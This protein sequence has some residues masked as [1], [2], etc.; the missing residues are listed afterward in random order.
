[1]R[2]VIAA[3]I[4][5]IGIVMAL[6]AAVPATAASAQQ[7]RPTFTIT[8]VASG[9]AIPWDVAETPDGTLIFDQR[10]GGLSVRRPNGTVSSLSADFSDLYTNGETGLMGLVLDPG[11]ATNRRFYTCQGHQAG[12]AREIQVI[13]WTVDPGYT[14]A[15]RVNDPLLGG[16]PANTASGRHGGCRLRFDN[17]GALMVST[18]DA[19]TGSVPQDLTSLGGKILRINPENGDPAAGNPGIN[20][21]NRSTRL[22]WNYGHRNPQ[23]LALRPNGQMFNVEHGPGRDDEVNLVLSDRNYGWDPN[24]AGG[25][26][27]ESVPMTDLQKFPDAQPAS[28]SSGVPTVATSGATFLVG[29]QWQSWSGSLVVAQ[30]AGQSLRRLTFSSDGLQ[31]TSDELIPEFTGTY[32]RLR[33]AQLGTDGSL[34]LTTS[35]GTNDVI[36]KVTPTGPTPTPTPTPA[37]PTPTPAT[38]T[39]TPATPTPTPATPTPTPA[40]GATATTTTLNVI[41]IDLPFSGGIAVLTANVAPASAAGTV[42]FRDHDVN[43]GSPVPVRGGVAFGGVRFLPTGAHSLTAVFIPGNP[44]AF[45]PSTSSPPVTFTF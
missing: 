9:L 1:M 4:G 33:T 30:L 31:Q 27:D 42:Q 29:P 7:A 15:T 32:G 43:I 11:F 28:W 25:S 40:P 24:G 5:A 38:P 44:A 39:P 35:N 17:T 26:Y 12:T 23:G 19:A 3:L 22:I 36:L 2:T 14:A 16:I 37:T 34:Y 10:S 8:P 6:V 20:D 21:A 45:Q 18:G 41:P 13:A